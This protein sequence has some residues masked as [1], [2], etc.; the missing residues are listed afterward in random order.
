MEADLSACA[1]LGAQQ[2]H[3]W[4]GNMQPL[5]VNTLNLAPSMGFFGARTCMAPMFSLYAVE[6][7]PLPHSPVSKQHSP[8]TASPSQP[9]QAHVHASSHVL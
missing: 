4:T 9:A 6:P 5:H 3:S 2:V 8:C 7:L 1:S